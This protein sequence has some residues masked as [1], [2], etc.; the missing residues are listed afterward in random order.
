METILK[1]VIWL[2][3]FAAMVVAYY[4]YLKFRSKERMKLAEKDE[5]LAQLMMRRTFPWYIIGFSVLGIG[6]G[7]VL[8]FYLGYVNNDDDLMGILMFSLSI[9]FGAT[10]I[11][12]GQTVEKKSR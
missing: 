8:G 11:I 5:N 3:F 9:L 1:T 12:I 4:F 10:G 7:L 6:V 2:G